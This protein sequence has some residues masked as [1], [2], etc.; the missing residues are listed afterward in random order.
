MFRDPGTFWHTVLGR[1]MLSTGRLI[2]TDPFSFTFGGTPWIPH[3]WL[4]E[5]L[6][7]VVHDAAGLDGLLLVTAAVLAAL[8]A[9]AGGRLLRAG[10]HFLPTTLL[11]VL[12]IAVSSTH[13]HV[14]P[15]VATVAL[16]GF[17]VGLL[18]D[19]ESGRVGLGRLCWLVPVF[20]L[21]S[22]LHGAMPAGL[23]TLGLVVLGWIL[24]R[25]AGWES[26][27]GGPR[28]ALLA[29]GL[30]AAC[31]LS[32]LVNPYGLRLPRAWVAIAGSPLLPRIIQ[33][34]A[35]P[36]PGG[37]E[38]WMIVLMGLV[39]GSV[40]VGT[41]PRRPRAS[42]LIPLVWLALALSRVRNAPLFAI[43]ALVA[44][45]DVLPHSRASAWLARPGR[46]L[47]RTPAPV[48]EP[49]WRWAVVPVVVLMLA[50]AL[51]LTGL[52]VPVVGR[53]WVR[54]DPADWPVEL[55]PELR[56]IEREHP[57]GSRV[58]NE[59]TLGGFLVYHTPGLKIFIDD[60]CELYGDAWLARYWDAQT[61]APARVDDWAAEYQIQYALVRT[62]SLFD[63]HF[64]GDARWRR[65]GRSRAAVLYQRKPDGANAGTDPGRERFAAAGRSSGRDS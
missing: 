44:L 32:A 7:A 26:P 56:K 8:Y 6:M 54:L 57:E 37:Q 19:C 48:P 50:A 16:L 15:H 36:S 46:E 61:R 51:Q 25:L 11:V 49:G 30:V 22:N 41:W 35:P 20:I 5:C 4:S 24:A 10:L 45:A 64:A 31:G 13:F 62:G 59:F 58:F 2:E 12:A 52:R 29:V 18:G 39:Y 21:W 23:A 9:W 28:D 60:R 1:Q 14:R 3:S 47:F 53:G 43:T 42:W 17:T 65:I 33:E 63:R 40:L 34:H 38:F 55:L 27:V